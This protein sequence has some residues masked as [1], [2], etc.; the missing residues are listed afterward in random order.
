MKSEMR[1]GVVCEGV[2]DFVAIREFMG[3]KLETSS[4]SIEFIQIQP[5]PDRTN[6]GGWP[7]VVAWLKDNPPQ[8][9]VMRF[10]NGG[11]FDEQ[12]DSKAC[13]ALV[14]QIDTDVLDSQDFV[15][16]LNSLGMS[17][18]SLDKPI[19]RA[20]LVEQLLRDLS[21]VGEV[22]EYYRKRHVF[23][24]AAESTE[25][26]CIAAFH[27]VKFNPEELKGQDLWN[28]FME[29]LLKSEGRT[30]SPLSSSD[31]GLPTKDIKRRYRFCAKHRNSAFILS[32]AEQFTRAL[33]SL[34]ILVEEVK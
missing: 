25:A 28:A 16:H 31:F 33:H 4:M 14:I 29:V 5:R 6:S 22:S 10:L 32:Q 8:S 18:Q 30:S 27:K 26:W 20:A 17:P 3:A 2:T 15:S 1:I 23:V 21:L 9:R 24:G 19:E 34:A 11:I 12:V 13:D 7:Q